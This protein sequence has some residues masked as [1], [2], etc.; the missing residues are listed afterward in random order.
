MAKSGFESSG[1]PQLDALTH[2]TEADRPRVYEMVRK[3]LEDR[4]N[5]PRSYYP[6]G[7]RKGAQ[8]L[9]EDLGD[10]I[11]DM[12]NVRRFI[13]D[14]ANLMDEIVSHLRTFAN[15]FKNANK[16]AE[17]NDRRDPIQIP[18][19]FFPETYDRGRNIGVDLDPERPVESPPDPRFIMQPTAYPG[20]LD[21]ARR[22][23]Q[24]GGAA[25]LSSSSPAPFGWSFY[26]T[27]PQST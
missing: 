1:L 26:G 18:P 22:G 19:E 12:A 21:L 11:G 24:A 20:V 13:D 15:R 2:I 3:E 5:G 6:D 25:H 27:R 9:S 16:A 17:D 23:T 8:T 14:P 10:F 4:L 7:G